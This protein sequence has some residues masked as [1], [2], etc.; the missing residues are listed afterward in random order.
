[1]RSNQCQ[2]TTQAVA[3]PNCSSLAGGVAVTPGCVQYSG[4]AAPTLFCNHDD[5]NYL[6]NGTPSNHGWPCFANTQIFSF[7]ESN[8]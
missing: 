3:V 8:R 2:M 7:L 4:C 1:V 5:P 6:D